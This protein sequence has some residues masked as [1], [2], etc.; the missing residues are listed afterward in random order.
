[1][2]F[3]DLNSDMGESYGPYTMGNDAALLEIVTS[4][5]VACGFHA[6]DP[7]VMRD[8]VTKALK[9]NVGIG[10]HPGFMDLWG[11]GRRQIP[12]QSPADIEQIVAYQIGALQ[13]VTKLHGG[14]VTHFK[15]HGALGNMAAV[16]E[17]LSQAIVNAV[18][19]VDP[20]MI[21]VI[22]PYSLTERVAERAGLRVAREIFADRAYDES[23]YL[24]SRKLPGAVIHDPEIA[25]RRVLDMI[26]TNHI[27]T[28]T[29]T[30]LP[31]KIDS[32]CVHGDSSEALEMAAAVKHC[33]Q[34]NGWTLQSLTERK[35]L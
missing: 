25:A 10:A 28:V 13:A 11:F 30:R 22:P 31:V 5:N 20:D 34:A 21:F 9:E 27:T 6:G 23:G 33:L 3:I 16:D 12:G 8:T 29:G 1:M 15:A 19:A 4:A 32:I 7:L 26:E 17:G 14:R 2:K 24:L 18:K 35:G